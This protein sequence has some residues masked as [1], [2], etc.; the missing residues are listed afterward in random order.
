MKAWSMSMTLNGPIHARHEY[1]LPVSLDTHQASCRWIRGLLS[2]WI[3]C[4]GQ[5]KG[6]AIDFDLV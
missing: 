2:R 3:R 4:Q 1:S 6:V 5:P